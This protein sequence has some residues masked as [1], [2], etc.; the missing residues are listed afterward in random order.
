MSAYGSYNQQQRPQNRGY[1]QQQPSQNG[2]YNQQQPPQNRGYYQQQPSQNRDYYQQQP[3]QNGGYYQQQPPQNRGYYQQQPSQNRDYYQQKPAASDSYQL[4]ATKPQQY[5]KSNIIH[6]KS[7]I[8]ID[9]NKI[10]QNPKYND[11][12]A[13]LLFLVCLISYVIVGG[14]GVKALITNMDGAA[15]SGPLVKLLGISFAV[16]IVSG[17]LFTVV[18]F[19]LMQRW[20]LFK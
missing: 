4:Q 12:W 16:A 7:D 19:F 1:Y 2:G 18:Y 3:S 17:F 10:N 5:E 13:A 11:L 15:K 14:M 20:G 8:I 9:E 6:E